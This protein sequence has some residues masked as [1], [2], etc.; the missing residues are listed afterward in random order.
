MTTKRKVFYSFHYKNDVFRVQQI[1]NIGAIEGNKQVTENKWEEIKAKGDPAVEKWIEENM[2]FK[3]CVIVLIGTDTHK[4]KWVK[5]EIKKAW[6]D[7]KGVF[8]IYVH[9]LKDPKTGKATKGTN[10]FEQFTFKDADEKAFTIRC[11]NPKASDAYNDI[12]ENIVDWIET[13]IAQRK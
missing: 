10:P 8:G 6:E 9:N 3:S 13:A 7:G 2:K 1:R 12:K 11:Y 5:H 4:R